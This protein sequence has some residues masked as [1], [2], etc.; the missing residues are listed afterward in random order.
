[1]APQTPARP[2]FRR[3]FSPST[4]DQPSSSKIHD[5]HLPNRSTPS[6]TGTNPEL[7]IHVPIYGAVLMA[8]FPNP[9]LRTDD[10]PELQGEDT[11]ISGQLEVRMP[12]GS[13]KRCKKISVE[14][15]GE[16]L[17]DLDAEKRK[18]TRYK[19]K[20][21]EVEEDVTFRREVVIDGGEAGI[22][23]EEGSQR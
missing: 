13:T 17:I 20:L 1:M 18:D 9:A 6:G 22:E 3:L 12:P 14:V 15:W 19:G 5:D 4:Q 2:F 21:R 10:G 16:L 11:V 7:I 23:L 8:P